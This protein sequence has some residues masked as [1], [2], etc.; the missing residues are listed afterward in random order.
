MIIIASLFKINN[1]SLNL[2][3]YA[4]KIN[5]KLFQYKILFENK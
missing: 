1:N 2:T 3:V 4:G 5:Q